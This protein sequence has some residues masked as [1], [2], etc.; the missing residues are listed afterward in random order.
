MKIMHRSKKLDFLSNCS[1]D[2]EKISKT[3]IVLGTCLVNDVTDELAQDKYSI[4]IDNAT[5]TGTT[6][7]AIQGVK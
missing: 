7:C 6:I 1:F 4:S 3:S 2:E 5:V